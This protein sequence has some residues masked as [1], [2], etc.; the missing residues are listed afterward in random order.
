MPDATELTATADIK[1]MLAITSSAQDT[2]IALI[3]EQAEAW[4]KRF[5]GRDFVV[6]SYTEYYDGDGTA[7]LRVNQRPIVS[8]TSIYSDP[9]R[10]FEAASLIPSDDIIDEDAKSLRLGHVQLFQ[11]KFLKG[12]LSTKI[13]YS[14]GHSTIPTDLS[15]AVKLIICKQFKIITKG[16]FAEAVQQVGD[17]Q[18]TLTPDAFPKDAMQIIRSYRRMSF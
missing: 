17:M 14:A 3:K 7:F 1:S 11:Y 12:K 18:I 15:M 8:I 9:A 6:T 4:V 10:L 5:C 2:L 16:M 13:V